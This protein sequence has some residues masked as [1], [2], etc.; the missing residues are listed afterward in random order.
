MSNKNNL[1]KVYHFDLFGKRED[2]FELISK[3]KNNII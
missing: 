1:A 2:K 3:T